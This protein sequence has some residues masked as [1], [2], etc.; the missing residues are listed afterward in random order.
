MRLSRED[1]RT[2]LV[3]SML[4]V[5]AIGLSAS[6]ML[7]HEE[8]PV[9]EPYQD[10]LVL[11]LST[12]VAASVSW[13]TS[14]W[15]LRHVASASREAAVVGPANPDV[16]ISMK[17]LP[18]EIRPLVG[19]VNGAL[20]RLSE[21]YELERRFVAD[22]AHE[23]RTPLAVLSLRLQRAKLDNDP[24]WPAIN[25]DMLNLQKLVDQL[26]D[27]ARK[28]QVHLAPSNVSTVNLSRIAR[29]AAA[30]VIPLAEESGRDFEVDLPNSLLVRGRANDLRD[31]IRNLLDNALVHGSGKIGLVGEIDNESETRE[32]WVT[33]SD[34]G[35]GVPENFGQRIFDRFSKANAESPGH[36]LG[37]AIVQ[38]VVHGHG[39]TV[40]F[41][42]GP[43]C[44][45]RVKLPSAG[46]SA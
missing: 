28:E 7:H 2:R 37:L 44:R 38:E 17:R 45:I 39:G 46:T 8:G 5:F 27:L 10:L 20:D 4:L 31:M 14:A 29:E 24:D 16:R 34:K 41:L 30:M 40:N 6:L 9:P 32:V 35:S 22:A 13:V 19:A 23:L 33:V 15:S 12:F 42:P 25:Q 1:L 21:A 26:L 18:G 43:T 11:I 3:L 36:G